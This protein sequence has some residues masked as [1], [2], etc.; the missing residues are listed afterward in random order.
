[1]R[2]HHLGFACAD[3]GAAREALLAQWPL[4]RAGAEMKDAGQD[5]TLCLLSG[6]EGPAYELVAGPAVEGILKKGLA[7]Y[8]VCYEVDDL[9]AALAGLQAQGYRLVREPLPAPLFG[10]RRVAF[11]H[12]LLGLVELLER[13]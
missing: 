8:H 9:E 5:A 1:M 6:P 3:L 11:V 2:L 13:G 12:G 4:W 10:G 7:L